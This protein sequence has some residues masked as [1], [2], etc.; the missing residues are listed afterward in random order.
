MLITLSQPL[1]G[2][3]LIAYILLAL[4]LPM[5]YFVVFFLINIAVTFCLLKED[6]LAAQSWKSFTY[7]QNNYNADSSNES[8]PSPPGRPGTRMKASLHGLAARLLLK[9][10]ISAK[11]HFVMEE[12]P[13]HQ[14]RTVTTTPLLLIWLKLLVLNDT[15]WIAIY[16]LSGLTQYSTESL[17]NS[18]L[19]HAMLCRAVPHH[20]MPCY[21]KESPANQELHGSEVAV[22]KPTLRATLR[23]VAVPFPN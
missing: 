8:F 11:L 22:T 7:P 9:I 1:L 19:C 20:A 23:A 5:W 17:G 2:S 6:R 21:A 15:A 3:F 12:A 4:W 14:G 18:M 13:F 16:S 10:P